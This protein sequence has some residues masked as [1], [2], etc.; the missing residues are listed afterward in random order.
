MS[1]EFITFRA[2]NRIIFHLSRIQMRFFEGHLNATRFAIHFKWFTCE[3]HIS[4]VIKILLD[5]CE[6]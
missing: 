2:F 5:L 3:H 1:A 4:F 6:Q